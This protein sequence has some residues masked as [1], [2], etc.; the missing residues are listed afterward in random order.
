MKKYMKQILILFLLFTVLIGGCQT[1]KNVNRDDNGKDSKT[2]T[3]GVTPWTS[4]IPP[5][6]V[7]KAIIEDMGYKVKLQNADAGVVYAG[8]AKGDINV[9]MD[10]WLPDM[11]RNYMEK[12]GDKIDDVA[13][14]YKEGELG[15][16]V[17][18]YVKDINSIEDLMGK[19]KLFEN[20]LFGIEEGA[21]MTMTSREM[22]K[23]YGLDLEYVASSESG[24]LAQVK[25]YISQKKPILFLGWRPHSMFAKWDLK[26]LKDPKEYFKTSE[27]HVLTNKGLDK[28]APDVYQFLKNWNIS[29]E[30][31]EKMIL[32]I[33]NGKDASEVAMKWIEENKDKVNKMIG[34]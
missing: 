7:A 20:K 9:F 30:D 24:M 1:S 4:T 10:A 16:V 5:T 25:K 27:V 26:V 34:K 2:I 21:G 29:V 32:E 6:Y 33:E 14:S 11:H 31:I 15:W 18:S 8:L 3:F 23:G 22:I 13:I 19:E 12:Y 17:P 28:Q